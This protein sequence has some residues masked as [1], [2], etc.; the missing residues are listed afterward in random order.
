MRLADAL[1][2][3]PL[4]ALVAVLAVLWLLTRP[5]LRAPRW[6][7][8]AVTVWAALT[9]TLATPALGN[10]L[11]RLLEGQHPEVESTALQQD[12]TGAVVVL[13]SG[14][15]FQ[16]DG[17]LDPVLDAS[18]WARL[19]AGIELW[20]RVGGRLVVVGGPGSGASGSM[21]GAMRRA[22]LA[23]GVPDAAV[24]ALGGSRN[25]Y[26]DL[27]AVAHGL[28]PAPGPRWLVTSA[29]HMP[30]A[31]RVAAALGLRVVPAPCD[32]RQ[33]RRPGWRAWLPDNGA[34]LLWRDALH[35]LLGQAAYRARGWIR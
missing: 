32:Y 19:R 33:L 21:A 13:A 26:E 31:A 28:G 18:G 8:L 7:R 23:A 24:L 17:S 27:L 10:L 20:H 29:I 11:V 25:T 12:E 34:P 4:H 3:G 35:E 22:A 5:R 6:L 14:Q 9:W 15:M 30:R 2:P 1:V 16:G